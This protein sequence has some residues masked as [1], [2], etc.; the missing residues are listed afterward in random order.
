MGLKV[1]LSRPWC[2]LDFIKKRTSIESAALEQSSCSSA[3]PF[4]YYIYIKR[5]A[6]NDF[7]R[8]KKPHEFFQKIISSC[9][10]SCYKKLAD[11]ISMLNRNK[12]L[13]DQN[14]KIDILPPVSKTPL[15]N[16]HILHTIQ[17]SIASLPNL[18]W[19]SGQVHF[20]ST[21]LPYHLPEI[22]WILNGYL[23]F[24]LVESYLCD[25]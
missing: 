24:F 16:V 17:D 6:Y 12:I 9:C 23:W 3:D 25:Y 19:K 14:H 21:N 18:I 7:S 4:L 10:W 1:R 8:R 5:L 20:F 13:S 22:K 2:Y 15:L 11:F